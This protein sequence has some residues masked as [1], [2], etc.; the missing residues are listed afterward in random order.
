MMIG[1][2]GNCW[3]TVFVAARFVITE[4]EYD[5]DEDPRVIEAKAQ[6]LDVWMVRPRAT[7][8]DPDV[9][10]DSRI[11]LIG[12]RLALIGDG[13]PDSAHIP[14]EKLL[15]VIAETRKLLRRAGIKEKPALWAHC[16]IDLG[17]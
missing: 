16:D 6:G 3:Y 10:E 9:D 13:G 15:E 14:P 8:E 7:A 5:Q 2:I 11:Q 12:K 1:G 17:D 4:D